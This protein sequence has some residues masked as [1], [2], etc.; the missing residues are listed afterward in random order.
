MYSIKHT[1]YIVIQTKT[2]QKPVKNCLKTYTADRE[3]KATMY[4]CIASQERY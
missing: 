4:T 3:K 2:V 1:Q